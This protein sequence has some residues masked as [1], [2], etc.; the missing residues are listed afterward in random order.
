[1]KRSSEISR[2]TAEKHAATESVRLLSRDLKKYWKR[3]LGLY[4]SGVLH[5][6]IEKEN[7]L[8]IGIITRETYLIFRHID[9]L[10]DGDIPDQFDSHGRQTNPIP[11]VRRIQNE[12]VN[13]RDASYKPH[14]ISEMARHSL[15]LL[16]TKTKPDESA[17]DLFTQAIDM[18]IFD[19]RRRQGSRSELTALTRHELAEYYFAAFQPVINLMFIGVDSNLRVTRQR[20]TNLALCQGHIYSLRDLEDDWNNKIINIPKE[21]LD[22][23]GLT[24]RNTYQEL[25]QNRHILTWIRSE[26]RSQRIKVR[27]LKIEIRKSREKFTIKLVDIALLDH[28]LSVLDELTQRFK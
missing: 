24:P 1:M 22:K 6:I 11:T 2:F 7:D 3:V 8:D 16:E 13:T 9:D 20:L 28:M 12:I 27:K 4:V 21:E 17:Q 5:L 14:H 23:A 26:I 10:L 18:M 15:Q 25:I 19:Y